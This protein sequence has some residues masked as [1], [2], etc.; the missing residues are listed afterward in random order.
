MRRQE[1]PQLHSDVW[2]KMES[3][4]PPLVSSEKIESCVTFLSHDKKYEAKPQDA[5]ETIRFMKESHKTQNTH[6]IFCFDTL[7]PGTQN[8]NFILAKCKNCRHPGSQ[9]FGQEGAAMGRRQGGVKAKDV[10][11]MNHVVFAMESANKS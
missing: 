3:F 9:T 2:R 5:T 10:N 4:G 11:H 7:S 1:P 6:I 8:R